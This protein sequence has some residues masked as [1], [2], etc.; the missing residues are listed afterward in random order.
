MRVIAKAVLRD[1]WE[2]HPDAEQGLRAWHQA[3]KA[4]RWQAPADVKARFL[5]ASVLRDNRVVFNICGNKYRLVAKIRY[6]FGI[7]YIRFVGTHAEYDSID[8]QTV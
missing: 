7:V 1:F 5:S 3:A 8:A 4:A 6:E 2:I